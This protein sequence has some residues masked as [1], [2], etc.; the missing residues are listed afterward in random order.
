[1][2]IAPGATGTARLRH[3][4]PR[5]ADQARPRRAEFGFPGSP[6]ADRRSDR[7]RSAGHPAA[8]GPPGA[9]GS[10]TPGPRGPLRESGRG[11]QLA[12]PAGRLNCDVRDPAAL[13]AVV[14]RVA[15]LRPL[16]DE[17]PRAVAASFQLAEKQRQVGNLP[18]PYGRVSHRPVRRPS[19]GQ[20]APC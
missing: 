16:R 9:T 1:D 15:D 3:P 5:L 13:A 12:A 20:P 8:G 7:G 6:P 18:P 14:R 2:E 11:P 19:P 17:I 10:T 4:A